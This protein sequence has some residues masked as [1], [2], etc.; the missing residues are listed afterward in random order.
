MISSIP[1]WMG[2]LFEGYLRPNMK[3]TAITSLSPSVKKIRFEGNCTHMNFQVGYAN[4]IRVSDTDYRNYTVADYRPD[5]GYLEMI[6]HIH[7]NG[8]GSMYID[9]LRNGDEIFISTP[10]GHK[11]YDKNVN[12]HFF[13]GDETSLGVA[14]SLMNAVENNLH[15][16]QFYF[17]LHDENTG[18]PEL[19]G[20][21]NC[22]VFSG[23]NLFCN[24][25]EVSQLPIFQ[26]DDWRHANFILTGNTRSVQA[27]RSVLKQLNFGNKIHA[28]G[29]WLKGKKGL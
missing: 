14:T 10:R 3:I 22:T 6:F 9:H 23:K 15:Q 26:A 21:E 28:Q 27:F 12:K 1:K 7:G 19:L 11:V 17:E 4:V 20:L 25:Q 8:T 24:K 18:V 5:L 16:T 13:F 29:Y 2:H